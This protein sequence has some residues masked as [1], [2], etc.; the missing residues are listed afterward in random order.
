MAGIAAAVLMVMVA[1]GAFIFLQR[2][3]A[4]ASKVASASTQSALSVAVLLFTNQG[5]D[6]AQ[7][8]FA[9]GLTEDITRALG[10][11][12][13]LTVL[14][15]GAILPYRGKQL[16]PMDMGRA[17]N[18][19]FL[20]GGSVRR[21]GDRV[22]V[23]VQL[24]DAGNGT[25]L[26][27]EQYDDRLTDIFEVQDRIARRVAGTLAANLQQIA[28]QQ[29][30]RK[31]TNNLDAYDLLLRARAQTNEATRAGNR[32]ARETLERVARMAP[33]YADAQA[34]LANAT[35]QR[36]AYG[37]SEFADQDIETAIRLAQ[38]A[39]EI[40]EQCVVAHSVLARA[41]TVQRR[42]DLGLAESERA[43]Q[44]N[45][46]DAEALAA[47]SAV[48]LWTG[49]V[50]GSIAAGELAMRLNGN[51]GP[52][53][54]LDLGIAYLLNKRYAD[55]VRLLE[56]ARTRYPAYPTLDFPLAG[57][58]AEL[59]RD[60]EAADVLEQGKQKNPYLDLAGFGTRFQDPALK[61]RLDQTM[62]KA[63]FN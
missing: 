60:A 58:Y 3:E 49:D 29:S 21:I 38:K 19:R 13:Q 12:Q 63:G 52:E 57:A 11:F 35:F 7:D 62:R 54:A 25:Q 30:L 27:A 23:T 8:Y 15:Y 28:L 10:R 9:D 17:L 20:V 45:P 41:Y 44:L 32:M 53:P 39:L 46:N 48:L 55:A 50:E 4:P 16:A 59:G 47:R 31:P 37:W 6:P 40:D 2:A 51:L 43:L 61:R 5:G 14:A 18:A 24:T 33:T 36:A 22:R 34:E 42:Y 26:W 1:G 56:A